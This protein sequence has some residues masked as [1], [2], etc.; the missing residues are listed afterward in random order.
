[1]KTKKPGTTRLMFISI[2]IILLVF[3]GM[4]ILYG[5]KADI[6]GLKEVALFGV[7]ALLNALGLITGFYFGSKE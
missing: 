7:S 3:G 1:M 4:I 2:P 6:T 5:V